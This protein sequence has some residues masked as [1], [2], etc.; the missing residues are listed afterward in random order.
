MC[1]GG[2]RERGLLGNLRAQLCWESTPQPSP[3]PAQRPRD[4]DTLEGVGGAQTLRANGDH[5]ASELR[6]SW[7]LRVEAVESG[8]LGKGSKTQRHR[9]GDR[10]LHPPAGAAS[11]FWA[12][13][14]PADRTPTPPCPQEAELPSQLRIYWRKCNHIKT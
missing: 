11:A 7:D 13:H 1:D 12:V 3:R 9:S 6:A 5:P 10:D 8:R 14:T 4:R 2:R